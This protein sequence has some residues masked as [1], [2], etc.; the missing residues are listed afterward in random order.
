M[1]S[2]SQFSVRLVYS[3]SHE[4]QRHRETM[5]RSLALLRDEGGILKD[6][7]D[8][9]ILP[10]QDISKKFR[11]EIQKADICVFLI[12]Q[13]FIA[14]KPCR[15]EWLLAGEIPSIAR[16]P[17]ILSEC[18]WK[19][20]QDMSALK[21]LPRD[22]K[23][24]KNFRNKDSAWQQVYEG[25]RDLIEQLRKNFTIRS[26][27]RKEM[28]KTEFLS[29][30]H[31]RLQDIFVFPSMSSYSVESDEH[32]IEKP[33]ANEVELLGSNYVLVHGE[34]LSGKTALCRSLFLMLVDKG[35]PA[36]YINLDTINRR[37]ARL[38]VFQDAYQRQFR[39]D[40]SLWEKQ[41]HKVII[42]DN[43]SQRTIDHVTVAMEHFDKV[44]VMLSTEIFY[45]YYKDE[46]RLAK[47]MEIEILPLTH[48]KQEKLIRK[49]MEFSGQDKPVSDGQ[50]DQIENR[51]NDIIINNRILPRYPFYILS[52]LQTYEGFMPDDLSITSYGHCYYVLIIAHFVKSGIAKSDD[53]INA[54]INFAENLAFEIFSE[55]PES[56][57]IEQDLFENFKQRYGKRY[58][59][60]KESLLNRMLDSEYGVI[61]GTGQV[62]FR[63]PYMY[64]FFLGKYL[65]KNSEGHKEIIANMISR[66]YI[67][68]NCLTLIFTIHHTNDYQ[69]ID[70]ILVHTM[71]ALDDFPPSTLAHKET[72]VFED[73]VK[74]ISPQVL[75]GK[76]VESERESERKERDRR[77]SH[78]P[79][80]SGDS[81]DESMAVV[82][83]AYRIMK[84][85]DI[86]GQIVKNKYGS[87]ER[88]KVVEIIETIADGGL[89]VVQLLLADQKEINDFAIHIHERAPD[90]DIGGIKQLIRV[91][92]F[93]WTMNNVEK[94]V[95]ALNKPEIRSLVEE[96]V[97]KKNTPAYDLIEYFLRLDTMEEFSD[98]DRKQL[99]ILLKKH[100]YLFFQKVVSIR[101]QRYLNT[102]RVRTPV[103]QAVC[104]LLN[105][106]YQER[107]KQ[108]S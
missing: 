11:E 32:N 39:G 4:D 99:K 80:D 5:E 75:S 42:L 41:D 105:I 48:I 17:I 29:Q 87:L 25:L 1:S 69:I 19:D 67:T 84:N 79:G 78:A 62:N 27:Y 100:R 20:L 82:N 106:K 38:Q 104:S 89:R 72:R 83:D 92:S 10:G 24:V 102:H 40:F 9:Q 95:G 6:W 28:E 59:A 33:V 58:I 8:H 101:T 107:I 7:S 22:G 77:E 49:R 86:C 55:S 88:E 74:A 64:Y 50:I 54:C 94:I 56:Q 97:E 103:E 43:L 53:E 14:S 46:D 108:L 34:R 93:L 60:L 44:I 35:V 15:D 45:A 12:S 91:L 18:A 52:I 57:S 47:F 90:M 98:A 70:D 71:C 96:V 26:D 13:A 76:S 65:A 21:A 61:S 68:S 85:N 30:K 37:T 51:V 81:S 36:L 66:S 2:R 3:Y 23:P 73:I 63:N 16:V 31:I